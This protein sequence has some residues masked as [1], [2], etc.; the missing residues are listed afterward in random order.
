MKVFQIGAAGGVGRRLARLLTDR[1]DEVSGMYRNPEQVETVRESGAVPVPG[2]LIH[3]SVD[4]LA[5]KLAGHDAVVFSAGAHGTG[6]DQ[7][8]AIDGKGLEK[9]ADAAALAGVSRFVLVSVFPEAG[10][11]RETTEGFEHYMR[12][13]KIADAYLTRTDLNWLIVRPGTLIDYPGTGR[14]NA[15]L[16]IEY[17]SV[18]RDDVAAFLA[19][20][21]HEPRLDRML[22]ELTG[23]QTPVDE[24]VARLVTAT[25]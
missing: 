23:G 18:R 17:G 5:K 12:V 20:A 24:A 7:T 8:T 9:A 1:G 16:A 25:P 2:D 21:L 19:A 11:N 4:E 15:G 14:V 10:R 6:M 22:V 13:K 3:D